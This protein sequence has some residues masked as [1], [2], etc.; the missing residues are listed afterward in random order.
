MIK[1]QVLCKCANF[2]H[3]V[4]FVKLYP[5]CHCT[6]IKRH[7]WKYVQPPSEIDASLDLRPRIIFRMIFTPVHH[8]QLSWV[9]LCHNRRYFSHRYMVW[10]IQHFGVQAD[11]ISSLTFD[12]G[13]PSNSVLIILTPVK[14]FFCNLK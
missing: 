13:W 5:M 8:W 2:M 14:L 3:F 4:H 1:V 6:C 12:Y 7:F 11:Y 9:F 10:H